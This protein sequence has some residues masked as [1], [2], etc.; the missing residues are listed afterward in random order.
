MIRVE[1]IYDADCPNVKA[2][3]TNLMLAFQKAKIPPE[4][5]EWIRS[6]PE[7]P[8]YARSY[9]SP[10]I[11]INGRDATGA[12]PSDGADSCRLYRD[13]KGSHSIT[14]QPCMQA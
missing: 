6:D 8:S 9:G 10:T 3:R 2:A 7:A 11:F 1:L 14:N 13:E 5:S 12:T 4:W